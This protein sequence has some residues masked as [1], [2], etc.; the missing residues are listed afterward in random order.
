MSI[1][2]KTFYFLSTIVFFS[3]IFGY[4]FKENSAGGGPGDYNHIATNYNLI[5]SN[6]FYNINWD[7][8]DSSRFPLH[9]FIAKLYLPLDLKIIRFNNFVLSLLIPIIL[10][11]SLK[12]KLVNLNLNY[13]LHLF[14]PV[15]FLIYLSPYL[16]TSAYWMLEE[17]FGI[18]FLVTSS[19]FLYSALNISSNYKIIKIILNL[20]LI[21]C[22][23]YS[24]QNLFV[25]VIINFIFLIKYFWTNKFYIFIIC[26]L[27]TIFLFFPM[28]FFYDIFVKIFINI[29]SVRVEFQIDNIVDFFSII[30]IYLF[31]ISLICFN[32]NQFINFYTKY[33]H[34]IIFSFGA[35]LYFFWNYESVELG[36]GAIKKL[37]LFIFDDGF[38]Y[39][40]FFI[41]SSYLGLLL[42]IQIIKD[43]ETNLIF[44]I[45]PYLFFFIFGNFV[46]QEYL[47]P[48]VLIYIIL[49]TNI[50]DA[51]KEKQILFLYTYF[52][53]FLVGANIYY[54][55]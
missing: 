29:S 53:F 15:C 24:S 52:I 55:F 32:K 44:F 50:F 20:F 11:F 5:F 35:Y 16:R 42:S 28:I 21:Y 47:D 7:E 1:D 49:F 37:L 23:F 22:A 33:Y 27:N 14:I 39:K 2:K 43:K 10:V 4:F 17:N 19:F 41:L 6:N 13:Y 38:L 25:F 3:F 31:P 36:G 45:L 46:F 18:F 51:L 40:L 34:I 54:L 30:L 12:Q 9:Y 26:L 48:L 8:Y